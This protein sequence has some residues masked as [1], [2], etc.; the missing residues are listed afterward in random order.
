MLSAVHSGRLPGDASMDFLM[1]LTATFLR[2]RL[3]RIAVI[4]ASFLFVGP[5]LPERAVVAEPPA[6]Q[7]PSATPTIDFNRD[8]RPIL[9]DKCIQCHGFDEVARTTELRLD[10]REDSTA[11]LGGYAAIVPGHPEQ[12]ELVK[13]ITSTDRETRMPPAK[14]KKE[15]KPREILLLTEWIRQGAHYSDHW[16]FRP[17]VRSEF[18][19]V[20]KKDWPRNAID[21]FVLHHLE[22]AGL[23]PSPEAD[24]QTLIRRLW[25]DLVGLLPP[26]E[27]VRAFV[28]ST[29]PDAY[30]KLVSQLLDSPHYGERWGR[31]WLDQARYAD[32]NGYTID[33][34]RVMWPYRDW[35]IDA[36]NRDLPFD[37]FTIEQIAGDLLPE[38]TRKQLVASAYHRNTMINQEGGVKPD[39]YRAEALI[40]RV[41]TTASV[42]LGLT[43]GCAQ[44]HTHKFDP[45]SHHDYYR[46][47]AFF[48]ACQ[49]ANSVEPTIPVYHGEMF[50]FSE[51]TE[52]ELAELESLRKRVAELEHASKSASDPALAAEHFN[53]TRI[54]PSDY[55]TSSMASF[56][57][58]EDNSLLT[59]G[60]AGPNDSYQFAVAPTLDRL[61][62]VRLRVLPDESLPKSGPGTASNG[63][64]VLTDIQI[65]IDG[66]PY[67]FDRTW[68]DHA[69][70]DFPASAAI[71]G[72]SKTG[73]AINVSS[74]QRQSNPDLKMNAPHEA[75][76]VFPKP[77][78][79]PGLP[80]VV[81]MR[82]DS[83]KN[84]LIGRFAFDLTDTP[85]AE[86]K[87]VAPDPELERSKARIAE[88]EAKLPGG[89]N[90]VKQMVMRD[91]ASPPKT[92][93]FIR[94]DF[95]R[96]DEEAGPL[97]P[98][99]PDVL[100]DLPASDGPVNRLD[101]ARWLVSPENPLT[102]RVTVNRVWS[103]YFGQGLVETENDFGF[104][105]TPPSHPELLDWLASEFV[106]QG[107][108]MKSLHHL[109]VTSATYRQS[110]DHR[111]DLAQIDPT[112]KLLGRQN[113]LRVPAEIVRD[114]VLSASG[115]LDPTVGGPSV[116][117]PQP[118]GIYL[119]TQRKMSWPT[120]T[121][122]GR[123][124][125][126]MYTTFYRSAPFPWLTTFDSPDFSVACTRRVRSNTP[127]QA[128][129]LANDEGIFEMVQQLAVRVFASA[130]TPM[131]QAPSSEQVPPQ[132]TDRQPAASELDWN[133]TRLTT[134][135]ERCFSR[136]PT[137]QERS[138]L[139]RYW[140]NQLASF[141]ADLQA[142]AKV[143]DESTSA[144]G[145]ALAALAAWTATARVLV[146]TDEFITRE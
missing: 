48:N 124:R 83:N 96:P 28:D 29:D 140:Q 129:M 72:E 4:L 62:A 31:H 26:P 25:L 105:G 89:G 58:L 34:P 10:S 139:K 59:D 8:I 24:R 27:D 102:P 57:L 134:L 19:I 107:W 63:N 13:R 37:E 132:T 60:K 110:S 16:A 103:R 11:D 66:K 99:V 101:L 120:A 50:G 112:N 40:D 68:S 64:F 54:G 35:V 84:Y 77:L 113:R 131:Q 65:T 73:W 130:A 138:L 67:R 2:H 127:L 90:A 86:A 121:D 23:S 78:D 141:Q 125:R 136:Q 17:V 119:F 122:S 71:D 100:P 36:L 93:R 111:D 14:T 12:S 3:P 9:S 142:A 115:A 128:L 41:N 7:P 80:I 38:P 87:P 114:M 1:S 79:I 85:A 126:T 104:Q 133:D 88:L 51:S 53:W 82:H 98:D 70:P 15:L 21:H 81:Q 106:A 75:V 56:K 146:N 32:S 143:A 95:L 5:N 145:D 76:F 42:W 6:D 47:Y 94:G 44:C 22:E 92:Y 33:G 20:K 118:E 137:P 108:S 39:Q 49:D 117:P 43:I 123:F 30:D 109:I 52:Q 18:P 91:Q 116:H 55:M 144:E 97:S 46:L 45:I 74:E 69:Q 135:Y 61:T